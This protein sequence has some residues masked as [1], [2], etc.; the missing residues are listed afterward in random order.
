MIPG[1]KSPQ[2]VPMI[3]PDNGVK[4]I[5]VSTLLPS[6]IAKRMRHYLNVPR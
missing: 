5:L 2:R 1:S 3:S 4:P 6:L